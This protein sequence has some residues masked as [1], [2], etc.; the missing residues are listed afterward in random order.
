M[1]SPTPQYREKPPLERYVQATRSATMVGVAAAR[2]AATV[3]CEYFESRDHLSRP[4]RSWL[5]PNR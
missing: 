4:M 5:A 3:S 1:E 2:P